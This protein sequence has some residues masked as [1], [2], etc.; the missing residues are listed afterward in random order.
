MTDRQRNIASLFTDAQ[1]GFQFQCII[2]VKRVCDWRL[3][4]SSGDV[5]HL[6]A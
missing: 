1:H 6:L 4:G 2:R 3:L 5:V